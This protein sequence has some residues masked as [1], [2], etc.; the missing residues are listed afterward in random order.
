ML[1]L[2]A[3]YAVCEKL[4]VPA[5]GAAELPLSGKPGVHEAELAAAEARVP[6][7]AVLGSGSGLAIRSLHLEGSGDAAHAVVVV[8]APNAAAVELFVEGPTPDWA[9]PLP[10]PIAGPPGAQTYQPRP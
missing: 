4:C 9:L 2:K 10:E 3:A 1:R 8:S 7:H 5:E 6:R